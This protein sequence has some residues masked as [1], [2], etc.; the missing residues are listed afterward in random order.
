LTCAWHREA[1]EGAGAV[2]AA[3]RS[4]RLALKLRVDIPLA[5]RDPVSGYVS[6]M[7]NGNLELT[8]RQLYLA[9]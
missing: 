9:A 7:G 1:G 5:E 2:T 3:V 8:N 6:Q 4:G